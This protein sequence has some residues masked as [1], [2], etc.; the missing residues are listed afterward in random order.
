LIAIGFKHLQYKTGLIQL[1]KNQGY[2]LKPVN[3]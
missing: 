3:L 1:L 2:S